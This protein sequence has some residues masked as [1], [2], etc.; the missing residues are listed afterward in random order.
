M[1]SEPKTLACK[2]GPRRC[3]K[4]L[5]RQQNFIYGKGATLRGLNSRG[6]KNV[7]TASLNSSLYRY[8]TGSTE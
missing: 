1:S 8:C 3:Y 2:N 7:R 5:Q 6:Y 4:S